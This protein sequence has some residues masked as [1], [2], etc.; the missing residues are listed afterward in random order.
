[1]AGILKRQWSLKKS[2][3][4]VETELELRYLGD[5]VSAGGECGAAVTARTTYR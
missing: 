2:C 4:E 3:D 1:M 5:G